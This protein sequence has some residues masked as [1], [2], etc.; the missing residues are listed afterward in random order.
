[1]YIPWLRAYLRKCPLRPPLLLLL[2][3][4]VLEV[5]C[6][7]IIGCLKGRVERGLNVSWLV[8]LFLQL[9]DLLENHPVSYIRFIHTTLQF[10]LTYNFTTKGG[11]GLFFTPT[12]VPSKVG[13]YHVD[14]QLYHQACSLPLQLYHQ[15]WDS[16]TSTTLPPKMGHFYITPTMLPPKMGH[17]Y[18]TPTM[19][20]PKMGHIFTFHLQLYHQRWERLLHATLLLKVR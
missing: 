16:I 4:G 20:L 10:V 6:Q 14:L 2:F 7:D 18:I 9:L 1:M 15:K 19:L 11:T 5:I 8:C 13:Q 17:I 12:T 3:L